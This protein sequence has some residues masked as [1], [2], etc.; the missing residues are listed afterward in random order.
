[1]SGADHINVSLC[2]AIKARG[3]KLAVLYTPFLALPTN[4]WYNTWIAP[5][6]SSIRPTVQSCASPG[7]AFQVP[8]S[9]SVTQ[10]MMNMFQAV[11][12]QAGP[13]LTE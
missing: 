12:A 4:D 6:A 11:V 5:W 1:L 10:A 3:I 8:M 9:Q 2:N 7:L 13:R